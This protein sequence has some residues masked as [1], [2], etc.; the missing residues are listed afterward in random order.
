MND[1]Q[2]FDTLLM[3]GIVKAL[4]EQGFLSEEEL[5]E[6]IKKIESEN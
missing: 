3:I 6:C 2:G 1:K 5:N 4:K